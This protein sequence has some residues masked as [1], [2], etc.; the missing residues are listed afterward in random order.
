LCEV[1]SDARAVYLRAT[2]LGRSHAS[3][4]SGPSPVFEGAEERIAAP[5]PV[6]PSWD[7]D[8]SDGDLAE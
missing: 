2:K 8:L 1:L 7:S 6:G 4:P 3:C 5:D